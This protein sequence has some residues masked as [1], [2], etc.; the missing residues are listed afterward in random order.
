MGLRPDLSCIAPQKITSSRG[1]KKHPTYKRLIGL[2]TNLIGDCLLKHATEGKIKD[3]S[4]RGR[5]SKQL[6]VDLN[7]TRSYW[8]LKLEH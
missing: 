2:D 5:R 3:T 6:L 8:I 7:D 1:G 4:R